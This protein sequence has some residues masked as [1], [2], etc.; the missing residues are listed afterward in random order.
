MS[1]EPDDATRARGGRWGRG[2]ESGGGGYGDPLDRRPRRSSK[3][4][5]ERWVSAAA[6]TEAYGVV[7]TA[8]DGV[9]PR[10][11]EAATRELRD[12]RR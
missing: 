8:D 2:R 4:C 9:G 12:G 3:T 6:A 7:V 10:V 5:I 11:D 1:P